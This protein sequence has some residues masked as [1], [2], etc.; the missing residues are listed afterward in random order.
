M[1]TCPGPADSLGAVLGV[2]GSVDCQVEGY[3]RAAYLALSGPQSFFPVALTS[4]LVIY[5]ALIGFRMMLGIGQTRV[6]DAPLIALKLGIVLSLVFNWSL[7]E[8]LV[9]NLAADAPYEVAKVVSEPLRGGGSSLAADPL[10][11]LQSLYDELGT[12]A[13]DLG[14]KAGPNPVLLQG[15]EALA[16]QKLWTAQSVL[17]VST[18]GVLAMAM[19]AVGI[20]TALG[21]LFIALALLSETAGLFWGWLR[22]LAGVA[23]IPM[24]CWTTTLILLVTA[25]PW[26]QDLASGRAAGHIRL[27][28]VDTLSLI[29]FVFAAAQAALAAAGL[30]IAGGLGM[31]GRKAVRGAAPR[32]DTIMGDGPA[33]AMANPGAMSRADRLAL[34]LGAAGGG[35]RRGGGDPGAVRIDGAGG[36]GM[37]RQAGAT[38]EGAGPRTGDA[39]WRNAHLRDRSS[40]SAR[41]TRKRP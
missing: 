38:G 4:L 22:A 34:T 6:V 15:G 12:D 5:V 29:V 14:H 11:G 13:E 10:A 3:A 21:P 40:A 36:A 26:A 2:L 23:L 25:E 28:T 31:P 17:F 8:T 37:A 20:L 16:S 30:A 41:K 35:R 1:M 9:F 24:L 27:A 7:F 32:A 18:A 39:Y 33:P 19:I